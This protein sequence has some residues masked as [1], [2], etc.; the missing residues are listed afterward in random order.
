MRCDWRFGEG[1]GEFGRRMKYFEEI[2]K[3]KC[4]F[5]VINFY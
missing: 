2:R 3:G 4:V 5:Y 1:V